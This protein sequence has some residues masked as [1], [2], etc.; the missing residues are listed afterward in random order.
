MFDDLRKQA[1]DS[2]GFDDEL[3]NDF[4]SINAYS[5]R[6]RHFLGMTPVQRFV[7]AL[8]LFLIVIIT[9]AFC[10]FVTEK[11]IPPGFY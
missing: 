1:D 6:P 7:I 10:L 9:S 4:D 8:M 5:Y 3:E 2:D 11:I